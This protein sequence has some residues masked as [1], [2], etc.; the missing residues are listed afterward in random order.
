MNN[1]NRNIEQ[2]VN[3]RVQKALKDFDFEIGE[4]TVKHRRLKSPLSNCSDWVE[5]RGTSSVRKILGGFGNLEDNTLHFPDSSFNA[6]ALRSFSIE[7][8]KWS[9]WWLDGRY[10]DKLDVPVVGEFIDGIGLFFAD[11]MLEG[12]PIKIRFK[13]DSLNPQKPRWEQSFSTDNGISWE[14]NWT[15]DFLSVT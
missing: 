8:Q 3:T 1:D 10:P 12:C 7:T 5:F 2:N 14:I 9:I 6:I 13:W 15:M 4:W 11:D